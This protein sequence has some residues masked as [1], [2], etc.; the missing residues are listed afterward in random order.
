MIPSHLLFRTTHSCLSVLW[1]LGQRASC[2]A[3][4]F[5]LSGCLLSLFLLG[6]VVLRI[7]HTPIEEQTSSENKSMWHLFFRATDSIVCVMNVGDIIICICSLSLFC[8]LIHPTFVNLQWVTFFLVVCGLKE[9]SVSV[10]QYWFDIYQ[11]H[12]FR[13]P[14]NPLFYSF[15]MCRYCKYH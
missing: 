13:D 3:A 2:A 11:K 8:I 1:C 4:F 5:G 6:S 9:Y 10:P 12:F 15:L 14:V 7:L